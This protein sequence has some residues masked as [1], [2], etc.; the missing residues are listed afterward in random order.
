MLSKFFRY[1]FRYYFKFKFL[2]LYNWTL[3]IS[4]FTLYVDFMIRLVYVPI[5]PLLPLLNTLSIN[6]QGHLPSITFHYYKCVW[7]T[8]WG[9]LCPHSL[10]LPSPL[11]LFIIFYPFL[12]VYFSFFLNF[13][14]INNFIQYWGSLVGLF[15]HYQPTLLRSTINNLVFCWLCYWFLCIL[16]FMYLL[17]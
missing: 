4:H 7:Y 13:Y 3:Q 1:Y 9:L 14:K 10:L 2:T 17:F 15:A 5:S 16:Y 6:S 11:S 12:F 8:I